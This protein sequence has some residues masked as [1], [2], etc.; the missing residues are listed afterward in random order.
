MKS[1]NYYLKKEGLGLG[2]KQVT[3]LLFMTNFLVLLCMFLVSVPEV[4]SQTSVDC[5]GDLNGDNRVD[6]GD[7]AI[8]AAN[9]MNDC[10]VADMPVFKVAG[11]GIT[12]EQAFKFA[13]ALGIS[14]N[15]L[16]FDE[17]VA[18]FL[19]PAEFQK[20][21][22]I[23]IQDEA[24]IREL[25]EGSETD[26]ET[27]LVFEAFDF[28]AMQEMRALPGKTALSLVNNA[29][30]AAQLMEEEEPI[31]AAELA[32]STFEAFGTK[33]E[34]IIAPVQLD[35]RVNHVFTLNNTPLIGP[36]AQVTTSFDARGNVTQMTF[37]HRK[38]QSV[39]GIALTP[40]QEAVK[41][42][43]KALGGA[44]FQG[45]PSVRLVYYA[46]PIKKKNVHTLIPHYDIGGT[47]GGAT[48]QVAEMLHKL[49]PATDDPQF[50]PQITLNVWSQGTLVMAEAIVDGGTPP[51][52]FSW[53]SSSTD[54][55]YLP[56]DAMSFEYNVSRDR[57]GS[58]T[59][60]VHLTVTDD[61][62]ISVFA[63]KTVDIAVG[64]AESLPLVKAGGIRDFGVE[65]GV[66]DLCALNQAGFVNRFLADGVFKRF[67]WSGTTA[68][69]RDFKEGGT[70]LDHNYVDNVD[71]TFYCGHGYGGGFTFENNNDDN[72][73]TYTDAAGAW[74]DIDLEYM[75]LLSCQVLRKTYD[76]KEWYTRW[77]PAFDGLHL[78]CGFQTNAYDWSQF[79]GRFADY[80]LGRSFGFFTVT[81]P[82]RAAWFQAKAEEQPSSVESVVMGVVGPGG[83]I[84]GYN[85]YFWGHGPVG[86]DIR[87][88]NIRGYWRVV[89]K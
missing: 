14:P 46:P 33:G 12:E 25:T 88:S 44:Q 59:E 82:V 26:G 54:L 19:K 41:K 75:T 69:E 13:E 76:G 37:A 67:N 29:L 18:M 47:L 31:Q 53:S 84:S 48:G 16:I 71:I 40:P 65:R 27:Q 63:S 8:I 77:G 56:D 17:G 10:S 20:V 74:G 55:S 23:P 85:D 6:N 60:T 21:P 11:A 34:Q 49:V 32:N 22:T 50:V 51:Y 68:W 4:L 5:P 52:S 61:N 86:P 62:G 30:A 3:K 15:E 89:Y 83:C 24:L 58:N 43:E 36:G 73:L 64:A 35:T 81:M 38:L 42:L 80:T 2:L 70:G 9:W 39:A 45:T 57:L 66:S 87:G 79:G 78:L 72:W 7:L 28:A 1:R